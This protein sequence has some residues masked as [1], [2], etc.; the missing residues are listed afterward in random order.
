[1][2]NGGTGATD[3]ATA[4]S[5]LG[6]GQV[7]NLKVNL[8]AT[9][10]PAATDDAGSGYAAG[11]RWINTST[12]KEFVCLDASSTA[13]V[14][15]ET[16]NTGLLIAANDLSDLASASTARTNLG[17]GGAAVLNVGTA[18]STV[19]AGDDGRIT[20]AA[21]KSANLSDLASASTARTNLGLGNVENTAVSTWAGSTNLTTLGTITAGTWQGTAVAVANGGTGAT[22]AATARANLGTFGGSGTINTIPRFT[23]TAT[24]GDSGVTDDGTT[25]SVTRNTASSSSITGGLVV[26]GGVGIGGSLYSAGTANN[27]GSSSTI[28][29]TGS[30][31]NSVAAI[32][33]LSSSGANETSTSVYGRSNNTANGGQ[34]IGIVGHALASGGDGTSIAVY[35]IADRAAGGGVGLSRVIAGKFTATTAATVAGKIS[36]GILSD[37]TATGGSNASTVYGGSFTAAGAGTSP[38]AYGLYAT[39]S[40]AVANYAG[41]FGPGL[42]AISDTTASTSGSTGALSVAGGSGIAGALMVGT[43]PTTGGFNITNLKSRIHN[44][45]ATGT[46]LQ[47]SINNRPLIDWSYDGTYATTQWQNSAGSQVLRQYVNV[48]GGTMTWER[49]SGGN[50]SRALRMDLSGMTLELGADSA[51]ATTGGLGA[52]TVNTVVKATTAATSTTIGA[53]TVAGGTGIAGDLYTGN[54]IHR[55]TASGLTAS[56]TQT[57]GQMP[58]TKEINQISVCANANDTVTLPSAVSGERITVINNGAQTLR[59]FP[60]SGDA[61]N[62]GAVDAATTLASGTSAVFNSYDGTNWI[63]FG[64]ASGLT[65]S[66]ANTQIAF[67]NGTNTL[68]S[69]TNFQYYPDLTTG[70][71]LIFNNQES[72][73]TSNGCMSI[74]GGFAT[75]KRINAGGAIK[76]WETTASTSTTTGALISAGGLG[77]SGAGF[78]GGEV[79]ATSAYRFLGTDAVVVGN[80][81]ATSG[82]VAVAVGGGS[83]AAR[84]PSAT[85]IAAI[86]VGGSESGTNGAKASGLSSIAIGGANGAV[87]G[88]SATGLHAI[89][90][91][92][93]STAPAEASIAIGS[94]LSNGLG[95]TIGNASYIGSIAIGGGSGAVRGALANN[96]GCIA[97]GGVDGDFQAGA[98]ASGRFAIALG[99]L[100]TASA[101]AGVALGSGAVASGGNFNIAI[102]NIASATG[103]GGNGGSI[104]IGRAAS[105]AHDN[106]IAVGT[107]AATT[108]ANQIV[109]GNAT[110]HTEVKIPTTTASTSTT[111]GALVVSGGIGVAGAIASGG[112]RY[113][114]VNSIVSAAGVTTLDGT[115]HVVVVTGT[116]THNVTLPACAT[117]RV[118]LLKNRSTGDLT[119]T[120]N[121]SNT[122]DGGASITLTA[123]QAQTLVGNGT[124]WC[125]F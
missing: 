93:A 103:N 56:T 22:D 45:N 116:S 50:S 7:A 28:T 96:D 78:F 12:N 72:T 63:S 32:R 41:Y 57:Q 74:A 97:I 101:R 44:G 27:F 8:G 95:A 87:N 15:K 80:L 107:A 108:K 30:G 68:T 92:K 52:S 110:I 79:S 62:G 43:L 83:T 105:A 84:A 119:V 21:Q 113:A 18:A 38:T 16:T 29:T 37:A 77:V 90:M 3:A 85:A 24:F 99:S 34:A 82:A 102:G 64:N 120:P 61:I 46:V 70:G 76:S 115:D 31:I 118:L 5:N 59:I 109:L 98:L 124:D 23:G 14:W 25:V 123:N 94:A 91:G 122:I 26:A 81:A 49:Y 13:A 55:S 35:G 104:A 65:G 121:G 60:A 112:A 67:G 9:T 19:A 47:L 88:A 114:K 42:V 111:T 20:G 71:L 53:L 58:L 6:L 69:S 11:S 36:Y 54:L 66:A 75:L 86:A 125:A 40:G 2:A 39:A 106:G 89:A 4:R 117:G 48:P 17:L 100:T 51:A 10:N 73:T 33:G 1:M